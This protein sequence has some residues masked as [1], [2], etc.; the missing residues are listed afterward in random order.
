MK[1]FTQVVSGIVLSSVLLLVFNNCNGFNSGPSR[2]P[3][4]QNNG[5]TETGN[6]LNATAIV[7]KACAII[8]SGHPE[9]KS[10][11]CLTGVSKTTLSPSL[12]VPPKT[13][14]PF[15]SLI[16]AESAGSIHANSNAL[17]QCLANF[18][19]IDP[20]SL[21][22][23]N[24]YDANNFNP[25]RDVS[26]M[27]PTQINGCP[28]VYSDNNF[29]GPTPSPTPAPGTVVMDFDNPQP[30]E[31]MHGLIPGIFGDID[32][33]NGQDWHW[34][35]PY[36]ADHSNSVY[37]NSSF[38]VSFSF[39]NGAKFLLSIRFFSTQSGTVTVSDENG[40]SVSMLIH[41]DSQ[42][43][44]LDLNFQQSSHVITFNFPY[45]SKLAIDDITYR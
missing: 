15:D 5:G 17:A 14:D 26:K 19:A 42:M 8:V 6:G 11:D 2:N 39:V 12:G 36:D 29:V 30:P 32:F 1:A 25:F 22:V 31:S 21:T 37:P 10:I 34:Q 24:A 16:A 27:I 9:L 20:Q 28:I 3:S 43:H 41:A 38:P 45:N 18:D 40:Q 4:I 7:A 13:L 23:Q 35:V 44:T 33:G